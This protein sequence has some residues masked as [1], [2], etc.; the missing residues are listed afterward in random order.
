LTIGYPG[1]VGD[2]VEERRVIE[3][4]RER[5]EAVHSVADMERVSERVTRLRLGVCTC[6]V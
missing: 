2:G 6:A 4:G 1:E 5:P 3:S